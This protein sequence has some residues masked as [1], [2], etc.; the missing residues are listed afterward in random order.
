M[1]FKD[2]PCPA[3]FSLFLSFLLV[4]KLVDKTMPITGFELWISGVGS[5]RS[6]IRATATATAQKGSCFVLNREW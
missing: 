1:F 6:T 5:D 2:R 4:D 3:S